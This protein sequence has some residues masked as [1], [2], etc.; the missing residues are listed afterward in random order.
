MEDNYALSRQL[1]ALV[2]ERC[3]P[4]EIQSLII[5]E[6]V[7]IIVNLSIFRVKILTNRSFNA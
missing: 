4:V 6:V 1:S 2:S 5:I 7:K 3:S